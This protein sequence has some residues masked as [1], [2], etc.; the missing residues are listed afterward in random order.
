MNWEQLGFASTTVLSAVAGALAMFS[1]RQAGFEIR[2]RRSRQAEQERLRQLEDSATILT[3]A[4]RVSVRDLPR[5]AAVGLPDAPFYY[6]TSLQVDNLRCFSSARMTLRYPGEDES[7]RYPNVNR[8]LGDNGAGK[9]TLLRAAA[10]VAIGPV[11]ESS[12]FVPYRLVR[13]GAKRARAVG[14]L[15]LGTGRD[16]SPLLSEVS[17]ERRGDLEVS[18][19]VIESSQWDDIFNESSPSFL[20]VGYGVHRRQADD[21]RASPAMEQGKR[22]RR[23]QRVSSLFDESVTLVP[24]SSWITAVDE[25]RRSEVAELLERLLPEGI[26]F[27]GDFAGEDPIFLRRGVAVPFRALSD[28]F[29]SYLGWL[30]DLLFHLLSVTPLH[31]PLRQ[32]GGIVLVDEIDLL[33]HPLWQRVVVP[34]VSRLFPNI[35]FIFTTHSPIV[36]GTLEARNIAVTEEVD[37]PRT[38]V[39]KRIEAEVHGMNAEQVLL[40][41]YFDLVSSRAPEASAGLEKL[42]RRAVEGDVEARRRYLEALA[43]RAPR[44]LS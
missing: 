24:M 30:S 41:S 23:Y 31:V 15:V 27:T 40:S 10:M 32:M 22:R 11:L 38:A 20:V 34:S 19:S 12:G 18:R 6:L 42:A 5:P 17:V 16:T 7:L 28:G 44:D 9:S 1:A 35:Q 2:R 13:E 25:P 14:S 29:R 21:Y 36:T 39:V 26:S 33:L 37:D 4:E 43:G 8:L 3:P